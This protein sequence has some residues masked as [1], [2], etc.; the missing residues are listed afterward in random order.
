M[1]DIG[2]GTGLFTRLM[3]EKVGA[4]GKVYAVDIAPE[5]L[6]H[7]AA[8]AKKHGR[9]QI[10]TV[11]G[12]QET[13]QSPRGI[14]GPGFSERRLSPPRAAREDACVAQGGAQARRQA[15]PG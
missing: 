4:E 5:F 6:E 9:K 2:A 14:A 11:Q 12:N 1:A 8:D 3:A 15:G 13:T 7:I 10:V